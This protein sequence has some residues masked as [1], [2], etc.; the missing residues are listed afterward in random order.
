MVKIWT[1]H[2]SPAIKRKKGTQRGCLHFVFPQNIRGYGISVVSDAR[3]S[4]DFELKAFAS[5]KK[6]SHSHWS[7][8]RVYLPFLFKA[9]LG[10][11]VNA[12]PDLTSVG[13]SLILWYLWIQ[14]PHFHYQTRY[15]FILQTVFYF[16]SLPSSSPVPAWLRSA[17][18]PCSL[19]CRVWGR[20][21]SYPSN[22]PMTWQQREGLV[23]K[24]R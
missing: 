2:S 16:H 23:G 8:C 3:N 4:E 13:D 9:S 6:S 14:C 15:I 11:L 24:A 20:E 17:V 19:I 12:I 7:S 18:I 10:L 22:Y 1:S 5:S 21:L